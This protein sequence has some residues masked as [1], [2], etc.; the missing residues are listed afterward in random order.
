VKPIDARARVAEA[1]VGRMATHDTGGRLHLVPLCFVLAGETVY[2]A[3]DRKP[4]RSPA[5]RRLANVAANPDV[6]LLVD[7]YAE[8]WSA[9]WWVRLRG[10][11][12]V[13]APGEERDRAVALLRAKY[14][15]YATDPLDGPVLAID[16][17]EWRSWAPS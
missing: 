16:V 12:R 6:C 10:R 1:R 8:E 4:K 11:A 14:A 13:L 2:S 15:Q 5:L 17:D 9:L 7:E 3:V